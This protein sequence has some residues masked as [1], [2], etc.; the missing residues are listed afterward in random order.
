MALARVDCAT[1]VGQAPPIT[2][3]VQ[4]P[5]LTTIGLVLGDADSAGAPRWSDSRKDF[6]LLPKGASEQGWFVLVKPAGYYYLHFIQLGLEVA[7]NRQ[8]LP[9]GGETK[10]LLGPRVWDP[11]GSQPALRIEL[12]PNVLLFYVGTFQF[13]CPTHDFFQKYLVRSTTAAVEDETAAAAA[14]ARQEFPSLP[15]PVTRLAVQQSGPILIGVP[16]ADAQ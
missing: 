6:L 8:G 3:Q 14:V 13:A 10:T 7:N 16:P 9:P 2:P 15:P 5:D 4:L 12:P 11:L 1:S